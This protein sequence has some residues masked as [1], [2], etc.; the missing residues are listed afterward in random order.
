MCSQGAMELLKHQLFTK[1]FQQL[2]CSRLSSLT[3]RPMNKQPRWE[4]KDYKLAIVACHLVSASID[5]VARQVHAQGILSVCS[6][7]RKPHL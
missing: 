5:I 6:Q 2:Y 1:A 4:A 3:C 7:A